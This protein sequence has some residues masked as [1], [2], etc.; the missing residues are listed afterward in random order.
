MIEESASPA[1]RVQ[2]PRPAA[3]REGR[4]RAQRRGQAPQ[5]GCARAPAARCA[6]A[7]TLEVIR[8]EHGAF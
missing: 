8:R 3:T 4:G 1:S 2:S 7:G 6:S 5:S